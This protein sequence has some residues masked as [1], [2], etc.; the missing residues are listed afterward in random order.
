ME[1]RAQK[2]TAT[3]SPDDNKIRLSCT[4][5]LSSEDYTKLKNA[6]YK[7]APKQKLFI[8]PMWTPGREDIAL[9]FAGEITDEDTTLIERAG[10][11]AERFEGYSEKREAEGE[12]AQ[13]AVNA[14]AGN[15]PFGQPILIGHHSEK[16]ARRDAEKIESGMKRAVKLFET[17][18]YW[19]ERAKGARRHAKYKELPAVRARRIKKIEAEKRKLEKQEKEAQTA[20]IMWNDPGKELNLERAKGIAGLYSISACFTLEKYPREKA[21]YEGMRSLWSALDEGIITPE[22]AREISIRAIER[23]SKRRER[24]IAHYNNRLTYEKAMLADAGGLETDKKGPEKGGAIKCW[25]SRRGAWSYITKVNKVTVTILDNWDNGGKNFPRN[26]SFDDIREI[27]TAAE[28]EGARK[29][30]GLC[31]TDNKTGFYLHEAIKEVAPRQEEKKEPSKL[32]IVKEALEA[33]V[34][35]VTAP[36]L[37]VTPKELAER[38]IE[39]A[40]IQPGNRVLEPSAGTG[41][42]I[43][44]MGGKM[45]DYRDGAQ[46][47]EVVA[48]E[49]SSGLSQILTREFPL[50]KVINGDFLQCNGGLGKFDRII[51]NP[52]FSGQA[53]IEHVTHALK[54]LNEGGR[55]VAI[56]AAGAEFRQDRKARE[57]RDLI[58]GMG[59]TIEGLPAGSFESS[60]TKVNTVLVNVTK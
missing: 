19:E 33:G 26:V 23:G 7:W 17:A 52:P 53:D 24:W 18:E 22:E 12:R 36:E 45:F 14:I 10:E 30:G 11:R 9:A 58:E 21:T 28:V 44:A 54:F 31:E 29:G 25:A 48:V 15:I 3:Y 51:M 1:T 4:E 37:F 38:V 34:Q 32:E 39:E 42:L 57:F 6:G 59:G 50:T 55:L 35:V 16:R 13:E 20:A 5:R 41:A 40:D 8:A 46:K 2:F 43:G 47:G 60:G 56:M 49:I 27:M